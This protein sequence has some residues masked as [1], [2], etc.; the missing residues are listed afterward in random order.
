MFIVSMTAFVVFGNVVSVADDY[1]EKVKRLI[2][3]D[4]ASMG[5]RKE[6]MKM[7]VATTLSGKMNDAG[8]DASRVNDCLG[9]YLESGFA[10]DMTDIVLP[11]YRE[12]VTERQLNSLAELTARSDIAVAKAHVFAVCADV[13][14]D[15]WK[16]M[17]PVVQSIMVGEEPALPEEAACPASYKEKFYSYWNLSGMEKTLDALVDNVAKMG[18]QGIDAETLK[19][20]ADIAI[21]NMKAET[22]NAFVENVSESELD[23]M[24]E[25]V[26]SDGYRAQINAV[27][28][29][30]A[31]PLRVLDDMG[32]AFI[33]WAKARQNMN[34]GR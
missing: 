18:V 1:R 20:V 17:A 21:A 10:D 28:C 5:V 2:M 12:N 8:I 19:P 26:G 25:L 31:N 27:A 24:I 29:M 16:M 9:E 4:S 11:C 13:G 3:A 30:M 14:K 7:L 34:T 22:L 33:R 6:Q 15:V 32:D 23:T